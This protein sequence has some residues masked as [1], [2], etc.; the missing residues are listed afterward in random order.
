M[1]PAGWSEPPSIDGTDAEPGSTVNP[2]SGRAVE[3]LLELIVLI[4]VVP[5][6]ICC[7]IQAALSLVAIALP[8]VALVAIAALL[9]AGIGALSIGRRQ[10]PPPA[11]PQPPQ[12]LALPPI[13]RPS[14]QSGSPRRHRP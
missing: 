2:E 10:L 1:T 11:A 12:R 6:L 9:C 14:G 4:A 8:W 5:A 3:A 7:L 13:R